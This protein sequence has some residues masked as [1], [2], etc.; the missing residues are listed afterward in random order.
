MFA[1]R[2]VSKTFVIRDNLMLFLIR[3]CWFLTLLFTGMAMNATHGQSQCE[4]FQMQAL[5]TGKEAACSTCHAPV[6]TQASGRPTEIA[7]I[8]FLSSPAVQSQI[9]L[10]SQ[11]LQSIQ[12]FRKSLRG[13]SSKAGVSDRLQLNSRIE[14]DLV[15]YQI[16]LVRQ[17][18]FNQSVVRYGFSSTITHPPF[19]HD[20]KTTRLQKEQIDQLKKDAGQ[21]VN[22]AIEKLD[23]EYMS[24]ILA[25]LKSHQRKLIRQWAGENFELTSMQKLSKLLPTKLDLLCD[26]SVRQKVDISKEQWAETGK[27]FRGLKQ[28]FDRIQ[29]EMAEE[30]SVAILSEFKSLRVKNDQLLDDVLLKHQ[31]EKLNKI[32]FTWY[33]QIVGLSAALD[34][35]PFRDQ[36]QLTEKQLRRIRDL[37]EQK[38]KQTMQISEKIRQSFK[39]K[40]LKTLTR[41]QRQVI[42]ELEGQSKKP[43]TTKL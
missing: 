38:E 12:R 24:K 17:I 16:Q 31:H 15:P 5:A 14:A 33:Q 37:E 19:L 9:E 8:D 43:S 11:Q 28:K 39:S 1:N 3:R 27:V 13:S 35:P 22:T 26:A 20:V 21:E 4:L 32:Q 25:V 36:I 2:L 30:G 41:K 10:T 40:M 34:S 29:S 42:Q 7:L 23:N 6:S 18:Q